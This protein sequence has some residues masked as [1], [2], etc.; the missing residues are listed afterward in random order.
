M[1]FWHCELSYL[2]DGCDSL[3]M[4]S[5][6]S[7]MSFMVENT[8]FMR[9]TISSLLSYN[10]LSYNLRATL[11]NGDHITGKDDQLCVG[12]AHLVLY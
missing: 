8:H 3:S 11:P 9:R 2:V 6:Q 10:H 4:S 5:T 7:E 12:V 1:T